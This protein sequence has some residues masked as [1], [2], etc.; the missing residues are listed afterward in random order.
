MTQMYSQLILIFSL[1]SIM[2]Y[3]FPVKIMEYTIPFHVITLLVLVVFTLF[4]RKFYSKFYYIFFLIFLNYII[5]YLVTLN[6]YSNG[7]IILRSMYT[8]L[9][10]FILSNVF[11]STIQSGLL[12]KSA[13]IS[14]ILFTVSVL[15]LFYYVGLDFSVLLF[16][17]QHLNYRNL[18]QT[19]RNLFFVGEFV[20][21][22]SEG[23]NFRNGLGSVVFATTCLTVLQQPSF[24]RGISFLLGIVL[25]I[26]LLSLSASIMVCGLIVVLVMSRKKHNS[27]KIIIIFFAIS[28]FMTVDIQEIILENEYLTSRSLGSTEGRL[29]QYAIALEDIQASNYSGMYPGY[30]IEIDSGYKLYPHNM[31]LAIWL[32]GG[33][34]GLIIYSIFYILVLFYFVR[35]LFFSSLEDEFANKISVMSGYILIAILLRS[36][37]SAPVQE[38][39]DFGGVIALSFFLASR[40]MGKTRV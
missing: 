33:L 27:F 34:L 31:F 39:F 23:R 2:F 20:E 38:L 10:V 5:F 7:F 6:E 15:I 12:G 36:L 19:W 25:T 8:V 18:S 37:I 35:Y 14:I 9:F 30:R 40:K 29:G 22:V 11:I 17:I 26:S 1:Y 24:I 3:W 21:G 4:K 28:I 32:N 13:S 16:D